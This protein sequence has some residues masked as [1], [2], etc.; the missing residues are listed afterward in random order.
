MPTE[1]YTVRASHNLSVVG[2]LVGVGKT[3][4]QAKL[5]L[6]KL[7]RHLSRGIAYRV[8]K[9]WDRIEARCTSRFARRR[10]S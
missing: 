9:R 8:T 10:R 3:P 4:R 5:N 7:K 2:R 6:Q 1:S